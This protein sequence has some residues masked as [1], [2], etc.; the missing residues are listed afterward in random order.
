M[1]WG[2]VK[3]GGPGLIELLP[4]GCPGGDGKVNE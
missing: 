4:C 2:D 3:E 1:S